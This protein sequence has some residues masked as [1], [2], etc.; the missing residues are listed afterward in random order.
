MEYKESKYKDKYIV[1]VDFGDARTGLALG[2]NGIVSPARVEE[3]KDPMAV[4]QQIMRFVKENK[5]SAIVLGLP[6][7]YAQKET[8]QSVQV[9]RFAK[10]LKTR[11]GIPVIYVD[12]F[13][14]TQEAMTEAIGDELPQ[15]ARRKVDDISASIILK[16]FFSDEGF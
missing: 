12:E 10:I 13:G 15:K 6:L 7:S 16:R 4:V 3:S 1:G 5:A 14:S 11:L 2:K 9:R 8:V